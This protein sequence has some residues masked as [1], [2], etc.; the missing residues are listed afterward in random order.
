[1]RGMI[2]RARGYGSD[3]YELAVTVSFDAAEFNRIKKTKQ[4]PLAHGMSQIK[5]VVLDAVSI[6]G[7]PSYAPLSYSQRFP[8]AKSGLVTLTVYFDVTP[9]QLEALGLGPS[10]ALGYQTTWN[11]HS[12]DLNTTL[13]KTRN[14]GHLFAKTAISSHFG[15]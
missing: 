12:V 15:H 9:Y 3:G 5:N 7:T 1:M 4:C 11:Y 6:R 8:R 14:D 10:K 13:E 2:Q